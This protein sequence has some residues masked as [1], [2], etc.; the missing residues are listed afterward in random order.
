M[1]NLFRTLLLALPL[2]LPPTLA[3]GQG[4]IELPKTGQQRCWNVSGNQV[5]CAGTG[6]DG[7]IQAGAAW[8]SPRFSFSGG[9]YTDR[10]T[11]LTWLSNYLGADDR[12]WTSALTYANAASLCGFTD[13]RIPNVNEIIS[14]ANAEVQC[15]SSYLLD[16]GVT[17]P[18]VAGFSSTTLAASSGQAWETSFCSQ[19]VVSLAKTGFLTT[20]VVRGGQQDAVD[21]SYPANVWKTGQTTSYA[22]GD[23]GDLEFG[24]AWPDPRFTD[25][26][27][28]TVTDH[29]T[30]L[31]WTKAANT[32]GPASCSPGSTKKWQE[33]LDHAQCLNANSYL[34]SSGWRL[35]NRVEMRSL[36]DFGN[37][38]PALPTGH[39]FTDVGPS[40]YT[41]TT[42]IGAQNRA[43]WT[44]SMFDG[45]MNSTGTRKDIHRFWGWFVQDGGSVPMCTDSDGDG[46]GSPGDPSCPNGPE[47]DCDDDDDTIYPGATEICDGED[48]DCDGPV[49]EGIDDIVTGSDIGECRVQIEQC[50]AGDFQVTQTGIGPVSEICDG[51]DNDC[52][53]SSDE[54]FGVGGSCQAGVGECLASGMFVCSGDGSGTVCDATPGTPQAEICDGLDNDCDGTS[55]E[56]NPGGGGSCDTGQPGVCA[57]GTFTC[58]GG[59]LVCQPDA[60]AGAELCNGQDDDCDGRVDEGFGLGNSCEVGVGECAATGA[61]ICSGDGSGTVCDAT[62]GTPQAEI[63]DG[64][65]NDCDGT[66][67][68]GNPGGGGSCETGQPGICAPGTF[69]CS[70]GGL[71]CEPDASA[72]AELCNGQDDDCDGS[73]DEGFGLGSSCQVGV[74]ECAASGS[75]VC[76]G[77]GS[78]T[79]CDATP[80]TPQAEICDGLDNDC[81]GTSD[82][83]NPGGGG[84]CDTG[85]PGVCAPGTFTCSGGGLVCEPD[86][87][88]G[89]EICNGE[90]DDCDG[91]VDE[92]A[93]DAGTWYRDGDSDGFGDPDDSVSACTQPAGYVDNSLDCDDGDDQ[94]TE[95]NTPCCGEVIIEDESKRCSV[96]IDQ[97]CSDDLD[98]PVDEACIGATVTMQDVTGSGETTVSSAPCDGSL[99]GIAL[100]ATP[101]C[102][103][104]QTTA[105]F[106]GLAEVCIEYEDRGECQPTIEQ[107]CKADGECP[108][109]ETCVGELSDVQESQL[110]MVRCPELEPCQP[111]LTLPPQRDIVNNVL[112]ALTP[113]FS[114]FAVGTLTDSDGDFV[115]DLLDN[116]PT[117]ANFFQ[118]DADGDDVGNACDNCLFVSNHG[119]EDANPAE[120]DD[121]SLPGIQHYGDA[122]DADL[123][124]DGIVG[125][126]D[127]FAVFR[128]CLGEAPSSRPECAPADFDGDDLV[129]V[130]DFF[131]RLRPSLGDPAG[132]GHTEP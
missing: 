80:G 36:V 26:G 120:D 45:R 66:S 116:C 102:V 34:G 74:G 15:T 125:P 32:P 39:P 109:G 61:L 78:G 16:S 22:A 18:P 53:G 115:M 131:E 75:L 85:L 76:S 8:P 9:C 48:N 92:D 124:N 112:C 104:I 98:C 106:D 100:T 30:G 40:Y 105:S 29:L 37:S 1:R 47:T 19:E 87:S 121:S 83:G 25:H 82:E 128:P 62:P 64:L 127:F 10:L 38:N 72:G 2:I 54:G 13:W 114:D 33:L 119:Q 129:G 67:D 43:A 89:T 97:I 123:D 58:S 21:P 91:E 57:P 28:G 101:I 44:Q 86:A 63:C 50:I 94:V 56:G 88:A 7:D 110:T 68:E 73:V 11:G 23:D 31:V 20:V 41:S 59:G 65:D 17:F 117:I 96:T 27:N 55:D 60:S 111:L 52:D 3:R 42:I 95:C 46:Y 118:E 107:L 5:S 90:D 113:E 12:N 77:D 6:Q 132:P 49:D 24:V 35:P 84:S 122:C 130:N 93:S 99:Q 126:S 4:V 14:Q 103:D 71:V 79:V 108:P 51:L 70:G 81:D 69:T